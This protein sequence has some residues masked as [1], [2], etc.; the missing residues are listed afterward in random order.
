MLRSQPASQVDAPWASGFFVPW[1]GIPIPQVFPKDPLET[2]TVL[3]GF[4]I[5]VNCIG[6]GGEGR[7]AVGLQRL[8][9]QPREE[10]DQMREV[11]LGDGGSAALLKAGEGDGA[12]LFP[13]GTP[14]WKAR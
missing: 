9:G 11:P 12:F 4:G 10:A 3:E 14:R 2:P 7:A 1:F 8:R 6:K 13:S 5:G